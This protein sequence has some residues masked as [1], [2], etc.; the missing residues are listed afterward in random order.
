MSQFAVKMEPTEMRKGHWS[1]HKNQAGAVMKG[2][3]LAKKE[4][5]REVLILQMIPTGDLLGS[6]WETVVTI[7]APA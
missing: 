6:R 7:K 1:S 5:G 3:A 4:P 2:Q